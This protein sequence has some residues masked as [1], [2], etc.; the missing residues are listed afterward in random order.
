MDQF[1]GCYLLESQRVKHRTYI[2]FTCDPRRRL[3]Q[4]NG[5]ITAGAWQTKRWRP[6]KM[7]LCVWGFPNK[8][9]ALQFE[10][11]WQHPSIS[12]HVRANVA[13]LGFCKTTP[14][15][16]QRAVYGTSK[17]VQVL[18]EMLQHSPF[19][20]M[21]LRVQIFDSDTHWSILPKLPARSQLPKHI[22]VNHGSFDDLEHMCA[23]LMVAMHQPV[24]C[25]VC[26]ACR[27]KLR[28]LDRIVSCPG[29]RHAFHVSC[30]A[31][32][33]NAAIGAK[34]MPEAT[35]S[36]PS[37]KRVTAWPALVQSARRLER[38]PE[39]AE[40]EEEEHMVE[41]AE[42]SDSAL[43]DG[44]EQDEATPPRGD[45]ADAS[46]ASLVS[47]LESIIASDD[48]IVLDSDEEGSLPQPAPEATPHTML[49]SAQSAESVGSEPREAAFGDACQTC[50]KA[51]GAGD[52]VVT[53]L[54]CPASFHVRCGAQLF[55]GSGAALPDG[56]GSCPCCRTTASW[57]ELARLA[58]R[59]E[60]AEPAQRI[61]E[62]PRPKVAEASR[63]R[64]GIPKEP[65]TLRERLL[66]KRRGDP[67]VLSI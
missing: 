2:G 31:Q 48:A 42:D 54:G 58:R 40:A 67:S 47:A 43:E 7:I 13:H 9:A 19:C 20:G 27:E 35:G 57:R 41:E 53:C 63:P 46:K 60:P 33:F 23:E 49:G 62:A 65:E 28:A 21:P 5:E 39:P 25:T 64:E 30:A 10:H 15:G 51:F 16:R 29:C 12:R 36:C 56:R 50:S 52:R 6:W 32:A 61:A 34:L 24:V 8:I 37:C 45:E 14:R 18:L 3:R 1:F 44:S 59:I 55:A 66:K 22:S 17:N 11:A 38:A 26:A 4:H